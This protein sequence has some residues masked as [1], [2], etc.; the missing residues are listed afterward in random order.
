LNVNEEDF[1]HFLFSTFS[2]KYRVSSLN[3]KP[4]FTG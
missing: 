1:T 2:T 4:V 3:S